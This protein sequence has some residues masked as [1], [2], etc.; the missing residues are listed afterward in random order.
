[1]R[2][3]FVNRRLAF[4]SAIT[5]WA[6]VERFQ[7]LG[8]THVI[9]LRRN[10]HGKKIKSFKNLWLPFRD[11]KKPRPHWFYKQSRLFVE[12]AFRQ[13]KTKV[14]VMCRFGVCR[15]ASLTHFLLRLS[16]KNPNKSKALVLKARPCA[17]FGR[18]Y[19]ESSEEF[20]RRMRR[21]RNL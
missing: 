16:G 17:V 6:H 15:S 14:F 11:N 9:N 8:F 13:R 19:V 12:K 5:T 1:V 3:S 18:T 7:A 21:G 2:A 4:G 20:V 10:R